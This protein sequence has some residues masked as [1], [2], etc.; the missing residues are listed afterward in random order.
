LTANISAFLV[1][2]DVKKEEY[3][4]IEKIDLLQKQMQ[5]IEKKIDASNDKNQS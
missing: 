2:R 5:N 1:G 4:I 3:L